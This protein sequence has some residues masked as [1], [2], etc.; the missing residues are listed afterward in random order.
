[1]HV[2][3]ALSL[4]RERG[5]HSPTRAWI[6]YGNIRDFGETGGSLG[7]R[8]LFFFTAY[9]PEIRFPGDRVDVQVKRLV[10]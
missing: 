1:M 2:G 7:K 6:L 3:F 10:F 9:D 4:E 5:Q 8:C